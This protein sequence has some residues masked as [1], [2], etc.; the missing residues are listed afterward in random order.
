MPKRILQGVVVSDKEEKTVTV[1]VE[2][3]FMH[4]LYKKVIRRSKKY[5]AHDETN[6]CKVGDVISIRECRPISKRKRWEVVADGA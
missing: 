2:R 6:A 4:S 3:R 1:R 5:A